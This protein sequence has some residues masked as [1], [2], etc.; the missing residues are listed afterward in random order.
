MKIL[1]TGSEGQLGYEIMDILKSG[2]SEIGPIPEEYADAVVDGIDLNY[3]DISDYGALKE[4]FIH[5]NY[6]LIINCAALTNVDACERNYALAM[7]VNAVGARNMAMFASL[8]DA[9]IMHLSTDFVFDGKTDKPYVEWDNT[10]PQTVY[11]KSKLLGDKYVRESCAKSFVV[12]SAWMYGKRG[13][14]FVNSILNQAKEKDS[15][16]V[17]NDQHGNPTNSSDLAHHILKLAASEEYGIYHCTGNGICTWY[18]F[19]KEI[20]RLSGL[21]CDVIPCRTDEYPMSGL[22]PSYSPMEHYMLDNAVGDEMR[23]WQDALESHID[24]LKREGLL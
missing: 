16:M 18:D 3:L 21:E 11:G 20:V 13:K 10:N 23:N 17:V 9:K 12:R 14:H 7:K 22:R 4:Y 19:A 24:Y 5:D 15:I 8:T 1:V 6:E 2:E